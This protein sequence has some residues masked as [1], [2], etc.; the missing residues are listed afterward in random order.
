M[1]ESILNKWLELLDGIEIQL[2]HLLRVVHEV[3]N[4]KYNPD[5]CYIS[6]TVWSKLNDCHSYLNSE[7]TIMKNTIKKIPCTI[8][9]SEFNGGLLGFDKD[10]FYDEIKDYAYS[11]REDTARAIIIFDKETLTP[12]YRLYQENGRWFDEL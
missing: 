9:I 12:Y 5:D 8:I 10:L 1:G 2:K 3:V 7:L 11:V 6:E 4:S